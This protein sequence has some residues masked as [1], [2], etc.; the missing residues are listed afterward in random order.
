[1]SLRCTTRN[2]TRQGSKPE[3]GDTPD[4]FIIT[5]LPLGNTLAKICQ[6]T[7]SDS[8]ADEGNAGALSHEQVEA[9]VPSRGF[10]PENR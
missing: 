9:L 6:L 4:Y 10:P 2:F 1:M 7:G 5:P 3:I 8:K